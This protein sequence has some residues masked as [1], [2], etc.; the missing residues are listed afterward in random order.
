MLAVEAGPRGLARDGRLIIRFENHVFYEKWGRQNQERFEQYFLY[1]PIQ[2]WQR[3]EWRPSVQDAWRDCHSSQTSEWEVFEFASTL[4]ETAAKLS[5]AM[6]LT[7]LIGLNYSD[8]G[9]E[10]VEQM[11]DDFSSSERYQVLAV[12]DF[13][14]GPWSSSRQLRA[15]QAEDLDG[16]AALHYGSSQTVRYGSV[17]RSLY[18]AFEELNPLR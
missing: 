14:A 1:D 11:F 12:F 15:L 4:D 8:I 7:Q 6:G 16:F 13:I 17:L 10:S 5:T 3:H 18:E 9:Y 2:P